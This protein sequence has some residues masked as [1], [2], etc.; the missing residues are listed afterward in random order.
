MANLNKF[1]EK[2]RIYLEKKSNLKGQ[3]V[4]FM[5]FIDNCGYGVKKVTWPNCSVKQERIHRAAYMLEH[6]LLRSEVPRLDVNGFDDMDVSS[7]P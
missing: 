3:C 7:L 2:I 1:W 5:G 6:R 4:D